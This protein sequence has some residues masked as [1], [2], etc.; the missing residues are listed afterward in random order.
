MT[1]QTPELTRIR[2]TPKELES[3]EM[4]SYNIE[5]ALVGFDRDGIVIIDNAVNPSH[6]DGL[7]DVMVSDA[8]KLYN[9][10]S[11]HRNFGIETGNIQQEP[12]PF[13]H[14]LH[15]DIICNPFVGSVT[16][17][18]LGPRPV[19]RF[20]SANSAL[21]GVKRQPPHIDI[22][23]PF[24]DHCFGICVNINLVPTS[25]ENGATELWPGTHRLAKLVD[26]NVPEE[27]QMQRRKIRPPVRPSLPRGAIII[28]DFRLWH[29]GIPNKTE[30]P[31]IML[32]TV[33]FP[34]WYRSTLKIKLP[35]EA[36]EKVECFNNKVL[37]A[38]DY[39]KEDYDYLTGSHD[40]TFAQTY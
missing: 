15:E 36:K 10:E 13:K 28:R 31:R 26:H 30:D 19:V 32:V 25:A 8:F 29:A 7:N 21:K 4:S 18:L 20:Y 16:E 17:C 39:Q 6:L 1:D 24:N 23:F 22:D 38:A 9:N 3:Q 5:Q 40:F 35:M 37:V 2:L 12:V 34:R 33:Q 11:T 14:F 27:L